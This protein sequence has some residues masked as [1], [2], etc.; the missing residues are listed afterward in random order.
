MEDNILKILI[1]VSRNFQG[2]IV[3]SF[4]IS[5]HHNRK[6]C[7]EKRANKNEKTTMAKRKF[8]RGTE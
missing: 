4:K 5:L 1:N 2:N 3:S 6:G 8:S 7:N